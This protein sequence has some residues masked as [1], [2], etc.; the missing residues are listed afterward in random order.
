M[1]SRREI[2]E[3][4][5]LLKRHGLRVDITGVMDL[6]TQRADSALK[7][8]KKGQLA[9]QLWEELRVLEHTYQ[10]GRA[11]PAGASFTE[12]RVNSRRALVD[13]VYRVRH[14]LANTWLANYSE[15]ADKEDE[16]LPLPHHRSGGHY[17]W[18]WSLGYLDALQMLDLYFFD[19]ENRASRGIS[20]AWTIST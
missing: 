11:A 14:A 16:S 10:P 3:Y 17:C 9:A 2:T 6:A 8:V 13:E 4:Q 15:R 20:G 1:E 7:R 18:D 5:N 12:T 19:A